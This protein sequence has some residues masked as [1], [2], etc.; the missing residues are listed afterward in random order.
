MREEDKAIVVQAFEDYDF[1][2]VVNPIMQ[3]LPKNYLRELKRD[4]N[5]NP[6][7]HA[8]IKAQ[9]A[10]MSPHTVSR[11]FYPILFESA[12]RQS[13]VYHEICSGIDEAIGDEPQTIEVHIHRLYPAVMRE[14]F[15]S[16]DEAVDY[17]KH[18]DFARTITHKM[19]QTGKIPLPL[20]TEAQS[21]LL[22]IRKVQLYPYFFDVQR[23]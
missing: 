4:H 11:S 12:A 19:L 16:L 18:R 22:A 2:T 5:Q 6:W 23:N 10:A 3:G 20:V 13:E 9:A 1:L 8:H 7:I 21:R 17:F 14:Y 15:A